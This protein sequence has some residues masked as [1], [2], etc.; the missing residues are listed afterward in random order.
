MYDMHNLIT[1]FQSI[2][3][4]IVLSSSLLHEFQP[5]SILDVVCVYMFDIICHLFL[6]IKFEISKQFR[7]NKYFIHLVTPLHCNPHLLVLRGSPFLDY[8]SNCHHIFIV[9][10]FFFLSFVPF[11]SLHPRRRYISFYTLLNLIHEKLFFTSASSSSPH[12]L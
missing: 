4:C 10:C 1:H 6:S 5:K 11:F 2:S 3:S 8:I 9:W 12:L 7:L